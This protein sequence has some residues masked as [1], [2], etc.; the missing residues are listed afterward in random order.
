MLSKSYNVIK[1]CISNESHS[2]SSEETPIACT[3]FPR[4]SSEWSDAASLP[5]GWKFKTTTRG[6]SAG[7]LCGKIDKFWS[8]PDGKVFESMAEVN[9]WI[10]AEKDE[11]AFSALLEGKFC[12]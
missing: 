10:A 3:S 11:Q 7:V 12:P 1:F 6:L 4:L 8:S 5:P 9:R 2:S